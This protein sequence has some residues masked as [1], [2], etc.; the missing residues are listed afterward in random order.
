MQLHFQSFGRLMQSRIVSSLLSDL[1]SL[2][3]LVLT[4]KPVDQYHFKNTKKKN[5][6]HNTL[7][8]SFDEECCLAQYSYT[9]NNTRKSVV[10]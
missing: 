9:E 8:F 6:L 1:S 10:E 2:V 4:L 7:K 5:P 3:H